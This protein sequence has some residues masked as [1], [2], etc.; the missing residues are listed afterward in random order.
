MPRQR[1]PARAKRGQAL[2]LVGK[3]VTDMRRCRA[4]LRCARGAKLLRLYAAPPNGSCPPRP[5]IL[6]NPLLKNGQEG[7]KLPVVDDGSGAGPGPSPRA[8][9]AHSPVT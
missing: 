3:S 7:P 2:D 4:G 5:F 1:K 6:G 9:G 8:R